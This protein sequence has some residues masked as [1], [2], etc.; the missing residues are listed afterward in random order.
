MRYYFAIAIFSTSLLV[1]FLAARAQTLPNCGKKYC[2]EMTSCSEAYDRFSR[3]GDRDLD[4][5]G[6]GI[7]CETVCGSNQQTMQ[8]RKAIEQLPD[9]EYGLLDKGKRATPVVDMSCSGKRYCT[10]MLT[11]EEAHFYLTS[12]GVG[13]LDRDS[14]GVPCEGLCR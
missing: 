8:N 4:R 12:C 1:T 3:C 2:T 9:Q 6:D 13:S 5:D 14:D 7:P 10:Q 11:C